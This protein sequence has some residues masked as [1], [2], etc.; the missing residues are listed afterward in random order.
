LRNSTDPILRR[1]E[2]EK[3]GRNGD[4]NKENMGSEKKP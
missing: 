4:C 1:R 2:E 3:I